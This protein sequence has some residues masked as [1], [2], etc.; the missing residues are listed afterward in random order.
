M[1]LFGRKGPSGFTKSSTAEEVTQGIDASGLTAIVTGKV[2]L[3]FL[4]SKLISIYLFFF[5]SY[6]AILC[7]IFSSLDKILQ[8][9]DNMDHPFSSY[10]DDWIILNQF[11]EDNIRILDSGRYLTC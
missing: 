10:M 4:S 1:W 7:S 8:L 11:L 3:L 6:H 9:E 2:H 5:N